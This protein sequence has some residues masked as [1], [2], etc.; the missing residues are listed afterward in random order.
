[1][2]WIRRN[3]TLEE[4]P[5]QGA[6]GLFYYYH[7]F[8]KAMEALGED[9]FADAAGKKHDWRKDLFEALSKRQSKDGGFRNLEDKAYGEA[10]PT[11]ATSFALLA[12]S[13]ATPAKK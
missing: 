6:S 10:D 12:L 1:V 13:Y 4:N 5:G 7:T 2:K 8:A 11:L 3:Y 9:E